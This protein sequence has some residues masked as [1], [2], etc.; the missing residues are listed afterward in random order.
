MKIEE[1]K[2]IIKP[3]DVINIDGKAKWW[4]IWTKITHWGI[5]FYQRRLFGKESNY[6]DT[7]TTLYFSLDKVFSTT[8][9]KARW[10]TLEHQLE[11]KF[12]VYRYNIREYSGEHIKFMEEIASTLID[13]EY[14]VG[15]LVDFLIGGLLGYQHVR[16]IRLFEFSRKK[17][18][19]STSVRAIQENLRKTLEEDD[20]FSF[21]RLFNKLNPEK[22]SQEEIEKFEKTD[23]EAT[24]P[25]HY[26]NSSWFESEF[27]KVCSWRD[28][29]EKEK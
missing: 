5:R 23:V 26:A 22:W 12:T 29:K 11:R 25:A 28:L 19:C 2:S 17:M 1:I 14:D 6:R 21:P 27:A 24:T 3:G 7:H 20:D 4:K 15:D 18:V 8:T 13:L 10:E 16:K 9:P